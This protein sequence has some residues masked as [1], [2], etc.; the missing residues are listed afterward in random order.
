MNMVEQWLCGFLVAIRF[1]EASLESNGMENDPEANSFVQL[2]YHLS[3]NHIKPFQTNAVFQHI[4]EHVRCSDAI[5]WRY[6]TSSY[7]S[8]YRTLCEP[9]GNRQSLL[10]LVLGCRMMPSAAPLKSEPTWVLKIP[11]KQ[12]IATT[13]RDISAVHKIRTKSESAR[14][15]LRLPCSGGTIKWQNLRML[16]LFALNIRRYAA[17]AAIRNWKQLAACRQWKW[18]NVSSSPSAYRNKNRACNW[19]R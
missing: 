16:S 14:T 4:S 2:W 1:S 13:Q 8:F 17:L 10:T 19:F 7:A 5:C 3:S 18:T 15:H 6:K 12:N 11:N 9:C